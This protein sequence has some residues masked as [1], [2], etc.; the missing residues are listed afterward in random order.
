MDSHV[1]PA[2]LGAAGFDVP[3]GGLDDVLDDRE[4]EAA[5]ARGAG[6]VGAEEPLEEP[7]RVLLGNA[8]AV[9]AHLEQDASV[10]G[11]ELDD[12]G[13]ALAGVPDRVLDQVLDD[14][15]EHAPAEREADGLVFE[16][17]VER[18]TGPLGPFG[19]LGKHFA[20]HPRGFGLAERDDLPPPFELAEEEEVAHQLRHLVDLIAR[21]GEER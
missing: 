9:V 4:A 3:A 8:G 20:E 16:A 18:D 13:G 2:A 21:P 1:E 5:P 12:A 17:K 15:A 7:W 11:P 10:V 6:A 14:R 19:A